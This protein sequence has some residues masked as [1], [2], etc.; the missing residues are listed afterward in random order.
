[1]G[2]VFFA[3]ALVATSI[4]ITARVLADLGLL[5]VGE[6]RIA[7]GAAITDDILAMILLALVSALASGGVLSFGTI[8]LLAA[9]AVTFIA[10]VALAG[11]HLARRY[12]PNLVHLRI[13]NAPFVVAVLLMLG[14]AVLSARLGLAAIIGAFLA[15]MIFAELR[16]EHELEQQ[17]RPLY[18]LLVPLFF[19]ITGSHVDWR[20]FVNGPVLALG[21]AVV[22]L[23]VVSK[24]LGCGIGA[25]GLGWRSALIIGTA[26]VPR[27]EVSL[28]VANVGQR[29]GLIPDPLFSTII[30]VVVLTTLIVPPLLAMLYRV[31]AAA[32]RAD[33]SES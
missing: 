7:L 9:E 28:I 26:M 22:G 33:P 5:Q 19:V 14:L 20:V 27:G 2:A 24:L 13:S 25:I 30:M 18:E 21:L 17:T 1:M 32:P 6:A 11:R 29:L 23:A 10:V 8:A 4:G 3:T 12:S 16:D 15:G 31:P